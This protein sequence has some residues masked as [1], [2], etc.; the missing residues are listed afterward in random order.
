M[1]PEEYQTLV[2]R[3][4]EVESACEKYSKEKDNFEEFEKK[5]S[6]IVEDISS[7]L[8]KD[9][10]VLLKSNPL[11]PG[12]LYEIMEKA[13]VHQI[14]LDKDSIK[15]AGG[16]QSS[17]IPIKTKRNTYISVG[18]LYCIIGICRLSHTVDRLYSCGSP[19]SLKHP[20]KYSTASR[21][22]FLCRLYK[23]CIKLISL[24]L[25]SLAHLLQTAILQIH[26]LRS[27]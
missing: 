19:M 23:C 20:R 5:R 2:S 14:V 27:S 25:C 26:Y 11:E 9:L 1:S 4:K 12:S 22:I 3:Y 13:R 24:C 16:N 8:K 7:V 21:I 6:R 17:R 15:T 10:D 18:I